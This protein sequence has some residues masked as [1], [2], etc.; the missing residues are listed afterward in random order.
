MKDILTVH[1]AGEV[2]VTVPTPAVTPVTIPVPDPIVAMLLEKLQEQE[3]IASV[4]ATVD[5]TQTDVGPEIAGGS[6]FTVT[7]RVV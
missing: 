4:T 3:G 6:G 2:H 1:P 7:I 5:P